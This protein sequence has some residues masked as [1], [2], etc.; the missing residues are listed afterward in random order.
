MINKFK[1]V[2]SKGLLSDQ[3]INNISWLGIAELVNRI[4][5]LGT[6]VTL[7]RMFTPQDYGILSIVFI[8]FEFAHV[9]TL[10]G[11]IGAKII[12]ADEKD[13]KTICDTAYWLNW[14]ICI[15]LFF[16]QFLVAFAVANF[17]GNNKLT[18]PI[19]TISV[20]YLMLPFYSIQGALIQ[21][22]NRLKILALGNVTQSILG[23]IIT[24]VFAILGM[25][26]WAA[27]W[28]SI[29]STPIWIIINSKY[30][31]WRRPQNFKLKEWRSI[32]NFGKNIVGVEFLNKLRLNIDYIIIGKFLG[33]EALGLYYFAFN[34]GSGISLN[35]ITTIMS[36]IFPYICAV[37][38]NYTEFKQRY[39]NSLKKI[40]FIVVPMI[41]AQSILAQFYVPI[42][43]GE[44]WRSAIPIL[45]LICLSVI[46]RPFASASSL[47]L[48]AVDKS[49]ISL[50][51]DTI[52]TIL[53]IITLLIGV[54]WGIFGVAIAVFIS[55]YLGLPLLAIFN[56]RYAL[57][58]NLK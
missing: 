2:F 40:A 30:H 33:I 5:R 7:A 48:N 36:A 12:Q 24:V 18:L 28:A 58:I 14:I 55:H 41:F 6:T 25:G 54:H 56:S 17:Y 52:F 49:D 16:I 26:V 23:N 11:G 39:F 45:V 22:E 53:F 3:L 35:I 38:E 19:C 34:A 27:V 42:I 8:I 9:F 15:V 4:F 46:P 43:F 47:L 32:T 31:P 1:G 13:L 10:R 44:K 21:R 50:Y 57:N 51:G 29:L 37:R 20:V